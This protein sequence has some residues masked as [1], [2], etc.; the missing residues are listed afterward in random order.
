MRRILSFQD[1]KH[2]CDDNEQQAGEVNRQHVH[3]E[4]GQHQR[5]HTHHARSEGSRMR[6][7]GIEAQNAD[8]QQ[9][10]KCVGLNDARKKLLARGHLDGGDDGM[11]Q[12]ELHSGSV[13]ARNRTAVEL[14]EQVF[15]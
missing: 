1:K 13:K 3:G 8:D 12:S 2:E 6:E 14:R 5:D 7:F 11:R 10:K 4:Q 15:A 9:N